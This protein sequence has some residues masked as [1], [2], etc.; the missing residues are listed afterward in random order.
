[1]KCYPSFAEESQNYTDY[2]ESAS[3]VYNLPT[4]L[5]MAVS[6]VESSY[7]PWTLNIS[8]EPYFFS[9]KEWALAKAKTALESGL[10]FDVGMMQINSWWLKKYDI[11]LEAA[12]D[13]LANI[14]FGSWILDYEIKRHNNLWEGVGAYHSPTKVKANKY[15]DL[16]QKA[17]ANSKEDELSD[18]EITTEVFGEYPD[19][20][21]FSTSPQNTNSPML[22][23]SSTV[24][25]V[26]SDSMLVD[27]SYN[28]QKLMTIPF[29]NSGV[30]K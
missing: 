10:S 14:Y 24:Y 6:K 21:P 11:P 2:F 30:N 16:V 26:F 29:S 25:F 28:S 3:I 7:K 27:N 19:L 22:V 15:S 1:M 12:L 4:D 20:T 5:I 23:K 18:F 13:P 8:G 9:S 17:L